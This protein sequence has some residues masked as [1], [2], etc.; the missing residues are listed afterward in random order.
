MFIQDFKNRPELLEK[1][2]KRSRILI[3]E[4][5]ETIRESLCEAL[6]EEHEVVTVQPLTKDFSHPWDFSV[7]DI[8][9]IDLKEDERINELLHRICSYS[10][11]EKLWIIVTS[12][13]DENRLK[14]GKLKY[15]R[16]FFIPKPYDLDIIE[17]TINQI[18]QWEDEKRQISKKLGKR[19]AR[20]F[21][22]LEE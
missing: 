19:L 5:E 10:Y 13:K 20:F 7:F 14:L 18:I 22:G 12:V 21:Y 15:D 1:R 9:I 16:L 8:L 6:Q 2:G 11:T 17:K 3:Y 4:P